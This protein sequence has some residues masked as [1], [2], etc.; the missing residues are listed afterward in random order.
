MKTLISSEYDLTVSGHVTVLRQWLSEKN[1]DYIINEQGRRRRGAG[2]QG[3]GARA[4]PLSKV[5]GAQV[6]LCPPLL[7]RVSGLISLFAHI[8]W[9]KM[10]FF[11]KIFGSLRSPTLIN[12]YFPNFANLKLQNIFFIYPSLIA[13]QYIP[14]DI[15]I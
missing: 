13:L 11:Q 9:L 1:T 6:G 7:D 8:L 4:S 2:G 10:H 14:T 15:K 12:H 5:G 3:G